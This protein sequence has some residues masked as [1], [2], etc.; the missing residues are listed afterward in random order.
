MYT[1]SDVPWHVSTTNYVNIFKCFIVKIEFHD[2][3][4]NLNQEN[5]CH[6]ERSEEYPGT[7]V[8]TYLIHWLKRRDPST[9]R[10]MTKSALYFLLYHRQLLKLIFT[11]IGFCFLS[12][13]VSAQNIG[14]YVKAFG[15]VN[16]NDSLR[17]ERAGAR[18]QLQFDGRLGTSAAYFAALD[19]NYDAAQ[20][21][22]SPFADRNSGLTIYPVEAYVDLYTNLADFRLGQQFIFWGKADWVNPTD[23]INPWDYVNI[24]SEIEDYRIPVLAA[25]GKF[26]LDPF[27]VQVV[28]IPF[29]EPDKV[30]LPVDYLVTPSNKLS[31]AQYGLRVS[32]Y[33]GRIDYSVSY[34]H[35]YEG[36]PSIQHRFVGPGPILYGEYMPVDVLGVDFIT[37]F[38]AWAVKGESAYFMTDDRDGTDPFVNN[39]YIETVAGVDYLPSTKLSL[40]GQIVHNYTLQYNENV[41][42]MNPMGK[43]SQQT[44]SSAI[45]AQWEV[46]DYVDFQLINVYNFEH[47]DYFVLSFFNWDMADGIGLTVGG[48]LFDGPAG[49]PFGQSDKYDKIFLEVKA[50]F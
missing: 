11:V 50:S 46:I 36:T 38:G 42:S 32:S 14:G 33:L 9:S 43:S 40:T 23:N 3:M 13:T 39:P 27:T 34:F 21:E 4:K 49:S 1:S 5:Y 37:T 44:F 47:E 18:L 16:P 48:L 19:F 35:G 2:I 6:S 41:E 24:S 26:Y 25:N 10:G 20:A 15:Y 8:Q 45:R 12:Q 28:G 17:F 30:P 7:L 31:N 22:H 29:F